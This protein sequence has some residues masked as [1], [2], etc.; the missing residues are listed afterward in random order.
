MNRITARSQLLIRRQ[1]IWLVMLTV[2]IGAR[3]AVADWN[4]TIAAGSPLNWYR[5]DELSGATAV[6]YGS[7]QLNGSYGVGALDATRGIGGLVGTATQFGDQSTVFLHATDIPGDWSAEFVVNRIGSKQ[8][9]VLIRG[10]PFAFPSTALK[11]EQFQNTEQI[12]FTQFGSADYTFNPAVP[13]PLNQWIDLVY[14]NHAGS[15]MSLYLNGALVGTNPASI[16]LARDQIGSFA[17]T[18][19]ESP[20]AI[21]D[22]VVLYN[23]ALSEAEISAHFAATPEPSSHVLAALGLI[24]VGAWGWYRRRQI[25]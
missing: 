13:S 3:A 8:S 21:M 5:F 17:D 24:V 23:R 22:E 10:V 6:D 9:S 19:P 18:I 14:V 16:V 2:L 12:G 7:Q 11:L 4:S 1:A 15:G 20:L 25:K